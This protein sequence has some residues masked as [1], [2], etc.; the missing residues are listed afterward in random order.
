[1]LDAKSCRV[2]DKGTALCMMAPSGSVEIDGVIFSAR[3]AAKSIDDGIEVI[4]I[5]A[6]VGGLIVDAFVD[7]DPAGLDNFGEVAFDSFGDKS[8]AKAAAEAQ[9]QRQRHS[10]LAQLRKRNQLIIPLVFAGVATYLARPTIN[11]HEL[12]PVPASIG[13]FVIAAI[14][15]FGIYRLLDSIL[16]KFDEEFSKL[17]L[18]SSA[19]ALGGSAFGIYSIPSLGLLPGLGLGIVATFLCAAILPLVG[20][21]LMSGEIGE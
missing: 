2:G 11:I 8:K 20:I 16:I 7:Q 9:E 13:T 4:V 15:A 14:W 12:S 3:A 18:L 6:D 19:I 10:E 5:G 17:N 21:F 1:M